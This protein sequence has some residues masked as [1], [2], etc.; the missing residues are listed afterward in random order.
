MDHSTIWGNIVTADFV[1]GDTNGALPEL[2]VKGLEIR[3][4]PDDDSA[5]DR[6]RSSRGV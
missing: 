1:F 2:H 4:I 5:E 6:L 3:E